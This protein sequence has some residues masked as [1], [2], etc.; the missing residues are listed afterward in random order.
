MAANTSY[1]I[2][3]VS[4]LIWT[5]VNT[6]HRK[7]TQVVAMRLRFRRAKPRSKRDLELPEEEKKKRKNLQGLYAGKN[8][9]T[10]KY[11]GT[12][13]YGHP[14]NTDTPILRTVSFVPEKSSYISLKL[15]RL[16]RTPVNTDNGHFSVSRLTNS[17]T[18]STPIIVNPALRTLFICALLIVMHKLIGESPKVK[19]LSWRT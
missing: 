13:L 17:Y 11:S 18:S 12:P 3:V 4:K 10:Y 14:L 7:C 19:S 5:K 1:K 16:L 6:S 9:V 8:D 2:V 15:T